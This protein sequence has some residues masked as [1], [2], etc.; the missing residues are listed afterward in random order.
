MNLKTLEY[1]FVK[2]LLLIN[3]AL[4]VGQMARKI[5]RVR[6]YLNDTRRSRNFCTF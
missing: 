4:T 5:H 6:G 1:E 3:P 2:Q